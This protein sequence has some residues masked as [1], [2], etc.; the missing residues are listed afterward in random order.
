MVFKITCQINRVDEQ[1]VHRHTISG[2]KRL[3][4]IDR[5]KLPASILLGIRD[6]CTHVA[7]VVVIA[8]DHIPRN[9]GERVGSIHTVPCVRKSVTVLITLDA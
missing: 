1:H 4:V 9:A 7:L 6:L 5:R 3:F 8:G 2:S